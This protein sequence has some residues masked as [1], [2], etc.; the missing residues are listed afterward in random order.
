VRA[1]EHRPITQ[2]IAPV[3]ATP[4]SLANVVEQSTETID[5]NSILREEKIQ[6][7]KSLRQFLQLWLER[8][9][10]RVDLSA[11][12]WAHECSARNDANG[13]IEL[14]QFLSTL[15]L[16]PALR[17]ASIQV[18]RGQLRTFATLKGHKFVAR[19]QAAVDDGR[20]LGHNAIVHGIFL[21]VFSIPLREGL[22]SY[23]YQTIRGFASAAAVSIPIDLKCVKTVADDLCASLPHLVE[24]SLLLKREQLMTDGEP[25]ATVIP[26]DARQL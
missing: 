19:Y 20:A 5:L 7:A 22:L 15:P 23:G 3:Q 14:D 21:Y 16:S 8:H 12:R 11:I 1:V 2:Q 13:L 18:G 25:D 9:I 17:K 26:P 24:M 4:L 10:A 6:D